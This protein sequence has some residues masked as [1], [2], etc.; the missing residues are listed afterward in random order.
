MKRAPVV[1]DAHKSCRAVETFR[2]GGGMIGWDLPVR[3]GR[4]VAIG[5]QD[6]GPAAG[7]S[8][9]FLAIDGV[10]VPGLRRGITEVKVITPEALRCVREG[11]R[12]RVELGRRVTYVGHSVGMLHLSV[13]IAS[14]ATGVSA[15]DL[16]SGAS[17]P[18]RRGGPAMTRTTPAAVDHDT[19][20]AYS[21]RIRQLHAELTDKPDPDPQRVRQ[22]HEVATWLTGE[23]ARGPG[24]RAHTPD[25]RER[26]RVAV[27][28]AI[29]RAISRITR[30]DPLL[31]EHLRHAV[32]TG[33]Q[34]WYRPGPL[35]G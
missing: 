25:D 35:L 4:G 16:T 26:A 30:S 34:C 28:K 20:H 29:R 18:P 12:R 6:A 13:L 10:G 24:P 15:L 3:A 22:L 23:L 11:R 2:A 7:C 5:G 31:G 1:T 19:L 17:G 9:A 32:H 27:S 21:R 8:P 14:P 33:I